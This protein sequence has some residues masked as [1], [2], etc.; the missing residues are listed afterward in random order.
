MRLISIQ[1]VMKNRATARIKLVYEWFASTFPK[2][3]MELNYARR[4]RNFEKDLWL[5]KYFCS[6]YNIAVDIGSNQGIYSRYLAK[7]SKS[8][9]CFECN[10]EIHAELLKILPKNAIL[11]GEALSDKHGLASLRYQT[12]NT[13][14][15][16]IE[17]MNGLESFEKCTISELDVITKTLDSYSLDGVSFIKID[18]EGHEMSVLRG[19]EYLLKKQRPTLL[20][21]IEERH[22]QGN[23]LDV[24]NYLKDLGY[25]MF[26]LDIAFSN[27]L[28]EIS[29]IAEMAIVGVY[30]Y[31]FLAEQQIGIAEQN[32]IIYRLG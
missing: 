7:F 16:T 23:T 1:C 32:G 20:I 14:I 5:T 29:N 30:N 22:C 9:H 21:E 24:P 8:V 2:A 28:V 12:S 10:R 27:R 11:H 3:N 26:Y 4:Y 31:W 19:A 6:S 17:G 25:K 15:G 13:G 18:V